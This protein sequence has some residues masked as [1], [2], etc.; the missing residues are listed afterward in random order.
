VRKAQGDYDGA[1][2]DLHQAINLNPQIPHLY[3]YSALA[4]EAIKDY[5]GA[6]KDYRKYLDSDFYQGFVEEAEERIRELMAQL[7]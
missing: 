3:Y 7:E 4:R 6:L 2:D 1:I 5:S